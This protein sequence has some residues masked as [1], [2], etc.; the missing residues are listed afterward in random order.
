MAFGFGLLHGFGFAGALSE[1]GIANDQ[2]LLSLLFF[3]IGIEIGQI[4]MIPI[5]LLGIYFLSKIKLEEKSYIGASYLLG[6]IG[7]YWFI[8]RVLGI[9]S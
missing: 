7:S 1:I 6:G 8:E 4:I 9:V 2:L 3:N 5:F